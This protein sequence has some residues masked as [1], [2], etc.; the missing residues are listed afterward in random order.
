MI[1][2]VSTG[3]KAVAT[4]VIDNLDPSERKDFYDLI[5]RSD[6]HYIESI[7]EWD[8][9][10]GMIFINETLGEL[11]ILRGLTPEIMELNDVRSD[12][13]IKDLDG[14][15]MDSEINP[16]SKLESALLLGYPIVEYDEENTPED[17][18]VYLLE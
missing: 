13:K 15:D 3:K 10:I 5:K 9:Y 8:V 11:G 16:V 7:N 6:V 4:I 1:E 12:L 17:P 18:A 14:F 2:L